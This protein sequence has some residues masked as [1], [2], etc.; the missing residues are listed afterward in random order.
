LLTYHALIFDE[1]KAPSEADLKK[2]DVSEIS[3]GKF[4]GWGYYYSISNEVFRK[5]N[6]LYF[7]I[8]SIYKNNCFRIN[9]NIYD[10]LK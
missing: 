1:S 8:D 6:P 2:V 7:K 4:N 10:S 9:Q 3:L 5:S